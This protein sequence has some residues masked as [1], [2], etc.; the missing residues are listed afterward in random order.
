MRCG[1]FATLAIASLLQGAPVAAQTVAAPDP[2]FSSHE[3]LQVRFTGPLFTLIEEK[4]K[5][6]YLPGQFSVTDTGGEILNFD[7]K[8]RARGNFR[9]ENCDYPPVRLNFKK[10]QTKGTLFDKQ[11]KLKLVVHCNRRAEYYQIV[12]QEY[13]AYRILNLFTDLSLN[14]RLLQIEYVDPGEEITSEPRYAFVI[15]HK[16]RAVKRIGME[17]LV[18]PSIQVSDLEQAQL[19]LT[20]VFQFFIGNT[21]FSPIA[22]APG[23]DCCHN[24]I[25]FKNPDS[26]ITPIPYDFDQSGF[27]DAPYAVANPRFKLRSV[28]ERRYRGRCVNNAYVEQSIQQFL[29][30]KDAIYALIEEQVG[31]TEDTREDLVRFVDGFYKVVTNPKRVNSL[32]IKRCI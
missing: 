25:M 30:K 21:D 29:D 13:L 24:Y 14:V 6:D 1:V 20:S 5:E 9:H 26:K 8:F 16:N 3:I 11:D 31:F 2:L 22:A 15:E 12:L 17:E 27:V 19:N 28:K 32:I 4:S 18:A 7:I 10:S 23:Q